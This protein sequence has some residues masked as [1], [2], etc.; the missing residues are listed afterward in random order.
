MK[1]ILVIR[2][3]AIGDIVMASALI[4]ALRQRWPD[5]HI[6]WLTEPAGAELLRDNPRLD[7]VILWPRG[8]WSRLW[9]T[10]RYRELL[11][12][13]RRFVSGLRARRFD[14]VLDTQGLLKSGLWA[15]LSGAPRRIGMGSREGSA[16]LMTEVLTPPALDERIGSEYLFLARRLDAAGDGFPMDLVL[17]AGCRAEA[18][19]LLEAEDISGGYA[20]LA[21]FTTRAQKHWLESRW[22]ALARRIRADLGLEAVL[23][24]G[25]DDHAAAGRIAAGGGI[26]NLAGRARL[27]VSAALVSGAR[28]LVG[29]DTG[30]THM[31]IALNVP[32]VTLFGSTRPYLDTASPLAR[33]LY[34]PMACSPCRR[35]PTC[36]GAFTC[37]ALHS[38]E[39]VLA[40]ARLLL[41]QP[42]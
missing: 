38:V 16:L 7:E 37:M 2:L 19:A 15:W 13:V 29:V 30:L 8:E 11:A 25:P 39:G 33:V 20:V 5:A 34:H 42:R 31:G 21:P 14:L 32:T 35:R 27:A 10:R 22:S 4:P 41:E 18:R 12:Q 28:L 6:A 17:G 1:R 40:T 26:H 9:R 36:G 23:L 24:G 3:S